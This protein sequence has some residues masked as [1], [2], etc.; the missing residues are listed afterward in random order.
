[1][2]TKQDFEDDAKLLQCDVEAIMAVAS[3]EA[4]G[5]GFDP[6]GFPRTLFE[7]HW[8]HKL[9]SGKFSTKYPS[10]SYPSW[11]RTKYGRTWKQEKERLALAA[12]LDRKAA[13]MSASWGLF[14]IMGFNHAKCGFKDVQAFVNAM[15]KDE[16]KQLEAFT[17]F[18][19][20][21]GLADELR[22]HRWSDFARL[23]NGPGFAK[24]NYHVKLKEA[25]N[26]LKG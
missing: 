26:K 4:N 3:V 2:L 11:D 24:N 17:Q 5:S 12:S 13:L 14:Q 18:I 8:F 6:E 20:N 19:L 1:M 7:G 15:C 22:E 10:I 25:Y 23:Y 21:S 9:T 16:N